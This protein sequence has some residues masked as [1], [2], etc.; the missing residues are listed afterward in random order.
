MTS[1]MV[2]IIL[3]VLVL[4]ALFTGLYYLFRDYGKGERALKALMFRVGFTVTLILILLVSVWMG[5][6]PLHQIGR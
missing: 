1:K 6:L 2:I 3:L 4:G 5:W